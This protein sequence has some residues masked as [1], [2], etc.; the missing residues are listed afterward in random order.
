MSTTPTDSPAKKDRRKPAWISRG[1][2][3][4]R[5]YGETLFA[6]LFIVNGI[7]AALIL[8]ELVDA[9]K[10]LVSLVAGLSVAYS[11][12]AFTIVSNHGVKHQINQKKG[13]K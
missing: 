5:E 1:G 9:S 3:L 6:M 2:T 11:A 7:A 12:V 13:K 8:F 10:G 4:A